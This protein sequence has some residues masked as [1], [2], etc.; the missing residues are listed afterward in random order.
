[1]PTVSSTTASKPLSDGRKPTSSAPPAAPSAGSPT[2]PPRRPARQPPCL[3]PRGPRS[4]AQ[5]WAFCTGPAETIHDSGASLDLVRSYLAEWNEIAATTKA[6][7]LQVQLAYADALLADDTTAEE[8]FQ[9]A[10]TGGSAGWPFYTARAQLAYAEW[11]RRQRRDVDARGPLREVSR[12]AGTTLSGGDGDD[13]LI[14]SDAQNPTPAVFSCGAGFD[15]VDA[16][17]ADVIGADCEDVTIEI[18][19]DDVDNTI[20]ATAYNDSIDSGEG[21][22][23]VQSLGGNDGIT[24]RGGLDFVDAGDGD[25]TIYADWGSHFQIV[26]DV[27]DVVC[28][29]G[30]LTAF[31][32][33]VDTVS[34]DCENVFVFV[35]VAPK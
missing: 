13:S 32:D 9:R 22:D 8:R 7:H 3:A 27:D 5:S 29:T 19:G 10:M 6:P 18:L 14:G 4:R 20:V 2:P 35:F 30:N 12:F 15:R 24:L 26:G 17:L 33:D 28:G 34:S 23:N 25:D 31:V 16:D 1:L 21:N 11:L